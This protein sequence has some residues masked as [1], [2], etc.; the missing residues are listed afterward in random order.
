MPGKS[1]D[2]DSGKHTKQFSINHLRNHMHRVH[3]KRPLQAALSL[4]ATLSLAAGRLMADVKLPAIIGDNML[5]QADQNDNIWGTDAPGQQI[6]VSFDGQTATA[7]AD[8]KGAWKATL[9][10]MKAG[11]AGD[12]TVAGS[13]TVTV[14]NVLVGSVWICSGQSNMEF[15]IHNAHNAAVVIPKAND[16][17]LR[18]FFVKLTSELTPQDDV[19][20]SWKVCTPVTLSAGG[21][22]GFSAVAYF[23]GREIRQNSGQPVGLIETCWGGT[24]AE[25]WTS[26]DALK[27]DP[28]MAAYVNNYQ[29]S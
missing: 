2:T 11:D 21:W 12:M 28:G 8:N 9:K 16:P 19:I 29:R 25:S 18:L 17:Q 10:P 6:T 22:G 5:L 4:A 15:G 1:V 23:F 7:A 14:H 20:A 27:S 26:I 24:P 13:N 3:G